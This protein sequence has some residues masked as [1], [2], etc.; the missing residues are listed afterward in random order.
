MRRVSDVA[1]RLPGIR[2]PVRFTVNTWGVR[3][4]E[5]DVSRE[6]V[7]ILCVGGS[8][9]ECLYV[10]DERTWPMRLADRLR[11]RGGNV[12]T[13]EVHNAGRS[14]HM[15]LHHA[16]L[17]EHYQGMGRFDLVVAMVGV[18]DLGA[19]LHEDRAQREARVAGEALFYRVRPHEPSHRRLALWRWLESAF[20]VGIPLANGQIL[21]DPQGHWIAGKRASRQRM[22]RERPRNAPPPS[23]QQD[24]SAYRSAIARLIRAARDR[25]V[26]LVLVTQPTLWRDGLSPELEALLWEQTNDA[27]YTATALADMMAAYNDALLDVA[28]REGVPTI[29]LA[30]RLPA[31]E[32]V[33]YDDCH[34]ND[35]GCEKVADLLTQPVWDIVKGLWNDKLDRP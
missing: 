1:D 15:A 5:P 10:T 4:P 14:G 2:G 27:A 8:A 6:A 23:W 33:F 22:L 25:G 26:P 28:D 11:A 24:L 16:H 7:R 35:S 18:N 21:Q 13:C 32:T 17:V 29:R 31:D 19:A 3:G 12:G 30:G 9:T 20:D 34:F